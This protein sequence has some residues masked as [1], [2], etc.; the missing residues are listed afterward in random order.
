MPSFHA[1]TMSESCGIFLIWIV[2]LVA[3]VFL[4]DLEMKVVAG[5]IGVMVGNGGFFDGHGRAPLGPGP[6]PYSPMEGDALQ[7]A[8]NCMY[9]VLVLL[10]TSFAGMCVFEN[11]HPS[12]QQYPLVW[13]RGHMMTPSSLTLLLMHFPWNVF[14]HVSPSFILNS[15]TWLLLTSLFSCL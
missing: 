13:N 6:I 1:T 7:H 11:L 4:V 12:F 2:G 14:S 10:G 15:G 5:R 9:W 8:M 3:F